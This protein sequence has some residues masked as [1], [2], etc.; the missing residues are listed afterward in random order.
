VND[1]LVTGRPIDD[2]LGFEVSLRPRSLEEYV[3]QPQV[4]A[5]LIRRLQPRSVL[6]VGDMTFDYFGALSDDVDYAI[7][8]PFIVVQDLHAV[9]DYAYATALGPEAFVAVGRIPARTA[10]EVQGVLAKV[11]AR[12]LGAPVGYDLVAAACDSQAQFR[13]ACEQAA[14]IVGGTVKKAYI[15]DLGITQAKAALLTALRLYRGTVVLVSHDSGFVAEL[16]P[17]RAV[18]MP[19]GQIAYFDESLLDLVALA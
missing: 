4:I 17:D 8:A 3:G 19:D 15:A 12:A 14:A 2:D 10:A 7:P 9:S 11:K 6:L 1:R 13:T 16:A 18:L 5:N